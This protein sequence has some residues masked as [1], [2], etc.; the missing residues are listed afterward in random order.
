VFAKLEKKL[1]HIIKNHK[2]VVNKNKLMK[3]QLYAV[4]L[5]GSL[6]TTSP[7]TASA[8]VVET[9]NAIFTI[10]YGFPDL[11]KTVIQRAYDD[12]SQYDN[13]DIK[14]FG[15]I[16]L[17]A[18]YLVADKIGIGVLFN[19]TS[20]SVSY[21]ENSTFIDTN[22]NSVT[23]PFDYT[24]K[25]SRLR[26]LPRFAFHFG[27]SDKF[28]GYFGV[29]AGYFS[30]KLT[31]ETNDPNASADDFNWNNLTPFAMRLDVGGNY[32]FTENI[33]LNFE[34]GLGGG[35]IVNAGLAIKF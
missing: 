16:G 2:F 29:A 11:F 26:I 10:Q 8:Q 27:N 13:L 5:L 14:G 22:G 24:L 28:D 17:R 3:K 25:L 34:I 18:E 21:I 32:F 6:F 35:P 19:Y 1:A 31:Y 23:S 4:L 12:V 30:S 7:G 9:G 15:P 20:T 33:G